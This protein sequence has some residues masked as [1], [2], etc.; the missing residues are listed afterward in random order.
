LDEVAAREEEDYLEH[1]R[2]GGDEDDRRE[3]HVPLPFLAHLVEYRARLDV[4]LLGDAVHQLQEVPLLVLRGDVRRVVERDRLVDR[5]GEEAE[6]EDAEAQVERLQIMASP[7]P[8]PLDREQ[9]RPEEERP[10]RPQKLRVEARQ[11]LRRV[12][13]EVSDREVARFGA[14]LAAAL[15][16]VAGEP[17][18]ALRAY[19]RGLRR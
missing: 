13:G 4:L 17:R 3:R 14:L 9:P 2:E 11:L 8:H 5:V 16:V 10:D 7:S 19:G 15:A 1:Q 6:G 12:L 18:A